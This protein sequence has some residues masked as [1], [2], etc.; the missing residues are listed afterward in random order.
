MKTVEVE[1]EVLPVKVFAAKLGIS[2]WT[3]RQLCYSGKIASVKLGSKL[4][5]PV[6]EVSRLLTDN[7]RPRL[8][9]H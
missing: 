2:V 4:L 5:V 6:G 8:E 7:L 1:P 3:A 9:P